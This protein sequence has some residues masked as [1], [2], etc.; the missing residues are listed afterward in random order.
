MTEPVTCITC[1]RPVSPDKWP[2][3]GYECSHL[4]CPYRKVVTAAPPE[5]DWLETQD[6]AV[7]AAPPHE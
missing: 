3:L 1:T 6:G 2:D 5:R 4:A 7:R